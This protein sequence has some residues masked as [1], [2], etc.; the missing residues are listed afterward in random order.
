MDVGAAEAKEGA[1]TVS[2][3]VGG[4]AEEWRLCCVATSLTLGDCSFS[5]VSSG[6][7]CRLILFV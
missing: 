1:E 4:G 6:M 2:A 5:T 3:A 7:E